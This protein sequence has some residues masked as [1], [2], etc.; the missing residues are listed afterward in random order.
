MKKIYLCLYLA[1]FLSTAY[2]QPWTV[3]NAKYEH[4]M[5]MTARIKINGL[6]ISQSDCWLGVFSGDECRGYVHAE[7]LGNGM[8]F[9]FLTIYG[10]SV[11]G[12]KLTFKFNN[13]FITLPELPFTVSFSPDGILGTPD[14][15][16]LFTYPLEF[17]STDFLGFSVVGQIGTTA[18]DK[19]KKTIE[20]KV[21]GTAQFDN[22]KPIFIVPVGTNVYVNNQLQ[23][24]NVTTNNF[25]Q[26]VTFTLK[27]FDGQATDWTVTV[28][29]STSINDLSI[30]QLSVYPNP[31]S[32]LATISFPQDVG[33]GNIKIADLSGKIVKEINFS[34]NNIVV[35]FSGLSRGVYL[36]RASSKSKNYMEKIL[37]K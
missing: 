21:D 12:E 27:G 9:F 5:T 37:I 2:A 30:E 8:Y 22:L 17:T 20:V 35:N 11:V 4:S 36:I 29:K 3:T 32:G 14:L 18:I 28:S 1:I 33:D 23:V 26:P 15:P 24:S 16:F 10:N 25:S 31:T 13:G 34:G 6:Y 7:Q 19:A